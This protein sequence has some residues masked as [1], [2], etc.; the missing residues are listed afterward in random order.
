MTTLGK[1]DDV[2]DIDTDK[3]AGT[4]ESPVAG[5]VR[6]L[7]AEVGDE[8]PVGA[9]LVVVAPEEVPDAEIDAVVAEA[10]AAAAS[11][12]LEVP[13]EPAAAARRDRRAEDLL[14]RR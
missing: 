4:L 5:P 13:D 3:I 7:V 9:V 11:G 2:V 1:G 10:K 14:L 12:A 6:R 8:L